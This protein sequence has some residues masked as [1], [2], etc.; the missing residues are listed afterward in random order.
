VNKERHIILFDGVCNLCN[1]AVRFFH[2]HD[3]KGIFRYQ[4]LQ[5]EKGRQLLKE[6]DYEADELKSFVY[7][8]NNEL[9]TKSSA[10]LEVSKELGLPYKL[11]SALLIIPTFLRDGVYDIIAKYR[12][13]WFGKQKEVCEFDPSF[14]EKII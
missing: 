8:R 12:Y 13:K 3:S 4:S 11:G 5:S 10:A 6:M 14:Q 1:G 2:R 9:F 7:I